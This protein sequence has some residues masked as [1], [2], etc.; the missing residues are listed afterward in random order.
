[1]NKIDE[2]DEIATPGTAQGVVE[3]TTTNLARAETMSAARLEELAKDSSNR[4]YKYEA[5][6][7]PEVPAPK[8]PL[9]SRIHCFSRIRQL[10][11]DFSVENP[12]WN[13]EHLQNV[14]KRQDPKYRLFSK[15]YPTV[16]A[17]ITNK[18]TTEEQMKNF[19]V[20]FSEC[21]K[22]ERKRTTIEEANG[23]VADTVLANFLRAPAGSSDKS[24][25]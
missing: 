20:I 18:G 1:M 12:A 5:A 25:C 9:E 23:K 24:S 14:I 3:A 17:A 15:I 22:L 10:Y 7:P 4:V 19:E 2:V 21:R 6:P 13:D 8:M 16:F 11:F